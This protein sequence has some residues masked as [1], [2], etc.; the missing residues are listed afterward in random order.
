MPLVSKPSWNLPKSPADVVVQ[1]NLDP[2][3]LLAGAEVAAS[4]AGVS[5]RLSTETVI[6]SILGMEFAWGPILRLL[7]PSWRRSGVSMADPY[8]WIKVLHILA[9][10]SWMAGLFYL[11]RLFVYHAERGQVAGSGRYFRGHGT[12]VAEG[13]HAAGGSGVRR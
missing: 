2:V 9:V 12:A 5:V 7:V 3:A 13:D 10:I 4:E 11:P 6:F 8:L 1:G